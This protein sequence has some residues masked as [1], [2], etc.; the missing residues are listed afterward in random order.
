MQTPYVSSMDPGN[1]PTFLPTSGEGALERLVKNV[2]QAMVAALG[3]QIYN[4]LRSIDIFRT[5]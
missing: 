2:L 1:A 4:Y 3:W 5:L